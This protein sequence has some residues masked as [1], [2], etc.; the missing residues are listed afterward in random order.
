MDQI[1]EVVEKQNEEK[2][3]SHFAAFIEW[4]RDE[5]D[6]TEQE[7]VEVLFKGVAAVANQE[8]GDQKPGASFGATIQGPKFGMTI[9]VERMSDED[10]SAMLRRDLGADGEDH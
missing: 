2:M 4:C 1:K 10:F 9:T 5:R 7:M 8:L 3:Q 6:M